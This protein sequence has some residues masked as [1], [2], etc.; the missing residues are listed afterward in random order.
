L[1]FL[2]IS[3]IVL[4]KKAVVGEE[5]DLGV[6][7]FIIGFHFLPFILCLLSISN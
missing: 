7:I 3:Q 1:S 4:G 6:L 5:A 2:V